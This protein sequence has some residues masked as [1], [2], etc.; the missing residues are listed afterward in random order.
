VHDPPPEDALA[1]REHVAQFEETGE[2]FDYR[3][4]ELFPRTRA[5]ARP[6]RIRHAPRYG[7]SVTIAWKALQT[8]TILASIDLDARLAV[9]IAAAVP[10]SW[11]DGRWGGH[12]RAVRSALRSSAELGVALHDLELLVRQRAWLCRI[13]EGI[14]ILPM[15]W[16]SAPSSRRF[17]ASRSS[18]S[19]RPTRSAMSLIQRACDEV[20]SSFASSAFASVATVET[21]V[22]SSPSK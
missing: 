8:K 5:G 20:Y 15:S 16:K 3:W 1:Q 11:K 6:L 7:R 9:R 12:P 18:A 21:N 14:P 22:R 13:S 19:S 4:V 2:R 17:I 10:A